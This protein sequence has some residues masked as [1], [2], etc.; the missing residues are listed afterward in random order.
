MLVTSGATPIGST[1]RAPHDTIKQHKTKF[2]QDYK[3][4]QA[5]AC[6]LEELYHWKH[7]YAP[8]DKNVLTEVNYQRRDAVKKTSLIYNH[9]VEP[10]QIR[11]TGHNRL[12]LRSNSIGHLRRGSVRNRTYT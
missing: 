9:K 8:E 11:T 6:S 1:G 12:R 4:S 3:E 10:T 7:Y 2:N 5:L